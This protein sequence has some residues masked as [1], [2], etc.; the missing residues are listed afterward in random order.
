MLELSQSHFTKVGT[1]FSFLHHDGIRNLLGLKPVVVYDKLVLPHNPV[2]ILSFS[3]IIL[4]TD[5]AQG[6]IFTVHGL[7]TFH[8]FTMDVDPGYKHIGKLR[9]AVQWCMMKIE[10]MFSNI[11]FKLIMKVEIQ[12]VS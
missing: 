7:G 11:S 4:E 2:D 6:K 3:Y 5:I 8:E 9:A 12:C 10:H 1:K